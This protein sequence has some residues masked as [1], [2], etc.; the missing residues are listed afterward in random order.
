MKH[1]GNI[2]V[3]GAHGCVGSLLMRVLPD[4]GYTVTG[5]DIDARYEGPL[6]PPS[7]K[8]RVVDAASPAQWAKSSEHFDGIVVCAAP[9]G[10]VGSDPT[11]DVA[12]FLSTQ[13]A[14][15]TR[16]PKS[17]IIV[18]SSFEPSTTLYGY[19]Q[20][21]RDA[22][23]LR[24]P[25]T[26]VMRCAPVVGTRYAPHSPHALDTW[27]EAVQ[28]GGTFRFLEPPP[29]PV[30]PASVF[31]EKWE[32]AYRL[33]R[34]GIV[35]VYTPNEINVTYQLDRRLRG[36]PMEV[37]REAS[38]LPRVRHWDRQCA[39]RGNEHLLETPMRLRTITTY[40]F[41]ASELVDTCVYGEEAL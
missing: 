19:L 40:K 37:I 24:H 17:R 23:A 14:I 39:K 28:K 16:F 4:V 20:A 22:L 36:D 12:S 38:A 33:Q 13:L 25:N 5:W 34:A 31:L 7:A 8:V 21:C 1:K 26:V 32:Y 2:L 3:V 6:F 41:D 15:M 9:V 10:K 27:R 29:H 11:N 18:V 30:L 35:D